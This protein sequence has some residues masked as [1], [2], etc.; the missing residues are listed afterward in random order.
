MFA[1]AD[2][3]LFWHIKEGEKLVMSGRF[4]VVEEFSLTAAGK[5]M[6]AGEWLADL[7]IFLIYRTAGYAGLV[8]FHTVLFVAALIILFV[9]LRD[10]L[11]P[12][13]RYLLVAMT[14]FAF[15]NFIAVRVHV[16]TIL[17]V[18]V[19]LL[20]A[21]LWEEGRRWPPW[22][23]AAGLALWVNLH[24]GFMVGWVILGLLC[25]VRAYESRRAADLAP[26][27][28]GTLACCLHP[29]GVTGFIY[30]VW[31]MAGAPSSSRSMILELMPIDFG[32]ASASPYILILVMLC[33]FGLGGIRR[34]FP[35]AVLALVMLAISLHN[36]KMLPLLS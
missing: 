2:P 14:A 20:W 35:W 4:P 26:W 10:E 24:G 9:F 32:Q 16:Y 5:S 31:F 34:R 30:P 22:A 36:R 7:E 3:D 6:V 29:N 8:C 18:A 17:F 15:I 21:R 11:P 28:A 27:A 12:A 13:L 19:Y 23:M 25:L 33:W 1:R